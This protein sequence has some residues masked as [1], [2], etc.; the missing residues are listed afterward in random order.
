MSLRP[1]PAV[2]VVGAGLGGLIAAIEL[3]EAGVA[4]EVLEARGRAGGRARSTG[5][6]YAANF[7]PHALYSPTVLWSW[8]C[9]RNLQGRAVSCPRA[10][11]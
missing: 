4:V 5:G 6:A 9:D 3:A 1:I 8:L 2:T 11:E 7:G 10:P